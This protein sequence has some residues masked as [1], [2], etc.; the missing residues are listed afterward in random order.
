MA[1]VVPAAPP[2]GGSLGRSR[3]S[4]AVTIGRRTNV[5]MSEPRM[6]AIVVAIAVGQPWLDE[7]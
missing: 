1:E 3:A 7:A 6:R 5:E 4:L 2:S